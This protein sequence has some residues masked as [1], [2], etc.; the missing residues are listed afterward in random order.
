MSK[1]HVHSVETA[2]A[3]SKEHFATA[4]AALGFVPNLI[5]VLAASPSAA[6][7]YLVLTELMSKTSLTPVEREVVLLTA[8][9]KNGCEYCMAAHST[10]AHGAKMPGAVLSALRAG[11]VLPDAKLEALRSFTIALLEHRGHVDG[12]QVSAFLAPGYTEANVLDVVLGTTMKT[13]SNY[14]NNVAHTP[15][16]AAFQRWAWTAKS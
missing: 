16:D 13:L 6:K 7:A 10:V 12:A 2:P 5:G 4:K 9:R 3:A 15:V 8:S 1:F 11:E 14:T